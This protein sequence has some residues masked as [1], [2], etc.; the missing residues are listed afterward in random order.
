MLSCRLSHPACTSITC[1]L[2]FAICQR[3]LPSS[4]RSDSRSSRAGPHQNGIENASIKFAD[5]SYIELITSS[6]CQRPLAREYEEFL[7]AN[8]GAAYVFLR[9]TDGSFTKQVLGAGGK[10]DEAGPF[11]F[12][13]FPAL[14]RAPHLQLIEYL[15]PAQDSPETYRHANG[16]RRV[17][18]EWMFIEQEDDP[19][20]HEL[21]AGGAAMSACAFEPRPAKPVQM[22][23]GTRLMLIPRGARDAPR[24]L[25]SAI[26]IELDSMTRLKQ[27]ATLEDAVSRGPAVW[28]PPS[29]M[30]GVWIGFV[31]KD[32]WK[33]CASAAANR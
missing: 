7:K 29:A 16:A 31:G 18:A 17:V 5:G 21:G 23:D 15:A 32:Q 11:A 33:D 10:R 27:V 22:A 13:E 9:D 26:L 14:W 1:R 25:A 6:P 30:H 24:L 3:P 28:L 12:T 8:E 2:R 19:I 4:D 20:A